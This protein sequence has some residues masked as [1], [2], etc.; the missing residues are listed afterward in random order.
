MKQQPRRGNT[1]MVWEY[2]ASLS[3]V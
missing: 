1:N 3:M 2:T